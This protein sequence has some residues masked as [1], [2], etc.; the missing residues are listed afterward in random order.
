M[1][2]T[3]TE[4]AEYYP[5]LYHM[6]EADSWESIS[7]HG[8]LSTSALLTLFEVDGRTRQEIEGSK[9]ARSIEVRHATI[10]RAV[11]RD[12]KPIVESKLQA[13]LLDCSVEEWYRLLNSR[14]FFWLTKER[15][16]TLLSAR[17][18][19]NKPHTILT[20]ETL[21]LVKDHEASIT[22]SPMNSGNTLPIAHPRGLKTFSK[23]KDYPFTERLKRGPYY[24]V[25]ELA[26]EGGV[27]NVVDYTIRVDVMISDGEGI[28]TI[29]TL[30][31]R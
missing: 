23:I 15:L 24:T 18:Y 12:Q 13:S 28:R 9:R 1:G 20:L 16:A 27:K 30:Y 5:V 7:K 4:L 6:A 26:V 10:G 14:V 11:I 8:L 21:P 25:V 29:R 22:L 17:E 31:T 19:R 3:P 2:V